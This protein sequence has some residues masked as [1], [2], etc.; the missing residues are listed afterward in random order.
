MAKKRAKGEREKEKRGQSNPDPASNGRR[1]AL[2]GIGAGVG[3]G[4]IGLGGYRAGWFRREGFCGICWVLVLV[5][6]GFEV[7]L[8]ADGFESHQIYHPDAA[9]STRA[10][11]ATEF[12]GCNPMHPNP[13]AQT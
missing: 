4:L 11:Y 6:A 7:D 3:A 2:I 12:S 10:T 13:I 1:N 5:E 9:K 8:A